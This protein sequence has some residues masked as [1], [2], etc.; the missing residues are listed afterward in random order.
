MNTI[1]WAGFFGL[2][3]ALLTLDLGVLNRRPHVPSGAEALGWVA[4]WISLGLGFAGVVWWSYDAGWMA[5][6]GGPPLSG[7][8]AALQYVAGYLI[9]ESLSIDNIFVMA[10][11]LSYFGIPG[12]YQHRVL[13]WG[14]AG[15]VVMRVIMIFAGLALIEAFHWLVYVFGLF[16]LV[17]AVRLLLVRHDTFEP[18]KNPLVRIVRRLYPVTSTTE[19]GHFFVMEGGRRAATPLFLALVMVESSD[20]LFA[21]D[22]VPAVL[23]ITRQPFIAVTSNLFAI[24]GLR[25]LYFAV[26]SLMS[27]FRHLKSSLVFILAFVGLKMILVEIYPV[28]I[29]FSLAMIGGILAVGVLASLIGGKSDPAALRPPPSEGP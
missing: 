24:L 26:A 16:L 25:A 23:A 27:R 28:P 22:S 3:A 8:E 20:L 17:T 15:A 9:E 6:V 1:I 10:M 19:G 5:T 18:D 14:I 29:G 4:F 11:I 21:V 2:I 13:F 7:S 12:A